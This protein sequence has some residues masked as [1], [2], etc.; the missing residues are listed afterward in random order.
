LSAPVVA[1]FVRR[2]RRLL[3]QE[4]SIRISETQLPEIHAVLVKHCQRVGI[5]PPELFLSDSVDHTTSFSW[6]GHHCIILSTHDFSTFPDAFD[7]VVDFVLA[8]EVGSICL[9]YTSYRNELLTSSVAPIPFLSG[10]LNH[11]RTF[12]RDRYGA[13]LAPR[14]FR[15]LIV[16]ASGDR[17][18]NRVDLEAYFAQL[19]EE[20]DSAGFLASLVWVFKRRVPLAHRVQELRRAGMLKSG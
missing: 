15:A 10:P 11:L 3:A 9:G 5:R 20:R 14:S 4:E 16:A 13:L 2:R 18:R 1:T 19:D 7:D 6:R 8:R 17:L 12:S